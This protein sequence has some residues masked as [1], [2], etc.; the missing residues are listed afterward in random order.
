MERL[1]GIVTAAVAASVDRT[2]VRR[3]MASLY[4]GV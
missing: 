2:K 4:V 1:R 3:F